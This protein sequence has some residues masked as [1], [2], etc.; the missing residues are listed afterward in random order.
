MKAYRHTLVSIFAWLLVGLAGCANPQL[1]PVTTHSDHWQG[2]LS[3]QVEKQSN[4]GLSAQF[5]LQGSANAGSL[6]L[7]TPLG[8]TL[9]NL[10]WDEK[11][12]RLRANGESREFLSLDALVQHVTGTDLPIESLFSWLQGIPAPALGWQADL[13]GLNE[14]R[15]SARRQE[16]FTPATLKIIL[17]R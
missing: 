5:D 14:G 7:T 11:S 17:D 12:A 4:Q 16:P 1:K 8:T 10:Q 2:R 6:T 9:A 3:I 13:N 15:L